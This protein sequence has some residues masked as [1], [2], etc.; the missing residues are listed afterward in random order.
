VGLKNLLELLPLIA[1]RLL[2]FATANRTR[3]NPSK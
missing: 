2:L 3:T 1:T